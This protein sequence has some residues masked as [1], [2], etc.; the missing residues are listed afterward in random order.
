MNTTLLS[1]LINQ[2]TLSPLPTLQQ[3]AD[4]QQ[5]IAQFHI[6]ANR[7]AE[8]SRSLEAILNTAAKNLPAYIKIVKGHLEQLATVLQLDSHQNQQLNYGKLPEPLQQLVQ[9]FQ[10][11]NDDDLAHI[12]WLSREAQQ[13]KKIESLAGD[14]TLSTLTED[15]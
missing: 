12:E 9:L 4:L 8:D 5:A 15:A 1:S 13:W 2:D 3:D 14:K 6:I 11:L 7:A 10:H